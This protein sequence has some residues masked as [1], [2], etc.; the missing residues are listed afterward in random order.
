MLVN[1][2]IVGNH[3]GKG[4]IFHCISGKPNLQVAL[5]QILDDHHSHYDLLFWQDGNL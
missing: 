1:C 4:E 2:G 3:E 5:Y